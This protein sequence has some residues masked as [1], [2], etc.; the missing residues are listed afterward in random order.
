MTAEKG[1]DAGGNNT[2]LSEMSTSSSH[3]HCDTQTTRYRTAV[4]PTKRARY[5]ST[6]IPSLCCYRAYI[7]LETC[8]W[9]GA[10]RGVGCVWGPP[11][12]DFSSSPALIRRRPLTMTLTSAGAQCARHFILLNRLC[13]PLDVTSLSRNGE[14]R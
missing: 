2:D 13:T 9:R 14:E 4:A 12:S 1:P 10:A 7:A 6:P 11:T 3:T 5:R 8:D